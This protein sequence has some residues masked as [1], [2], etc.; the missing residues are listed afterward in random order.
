MFCSQDICYDS[1]IDGRP[2]TS[3]KARTE[4][5]ARSGC[6]P[7]DPDQKQDQQRRKIES[8]K[9]LEKSIDTSVASSIANMPTKKRESLA[10]EM[11]HGATA[12]VVRI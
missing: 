7:Y 6:R 1:P 9:A 4:D 3:M 10:V 8:Q 11:E 5:L 2:I 12:E